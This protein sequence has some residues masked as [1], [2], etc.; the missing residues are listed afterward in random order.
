[1][2]RKRREQ[3]PGQRPNL[4]KPIN[5]KLLEQMAGGGGYQ[6]L[7]GGSPGWGLVWGENRH[8]GGEKQALS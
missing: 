1:M 5:P 8:L 2:N 4:D 7:R 6:K 3:L